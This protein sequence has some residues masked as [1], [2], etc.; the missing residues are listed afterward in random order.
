MAR[1]KKDYDKRQ[2]LLEKQANREMARA[3]SNA[4][5]RRGGR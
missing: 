5:R 1:G 3:M 4:I 2:A